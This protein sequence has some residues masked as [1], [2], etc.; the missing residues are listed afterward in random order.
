M[1]VTNN[2]TRSATVFYKVQGKM[3]KVKLLPFESLNINEVT[4]INAV[5][6]NMV[7]SNFVASDRAAYLATLSAN[8]AATVV[9]SYTF[10]DGLSVAA[11]QR[12]DTGFTYNQGNF[13]ANP[14]VYSAATPQA[15]FAVRK[16]SVARQTKGRFEVKY[17]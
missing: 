13:A 9:T 4:D 3:K 1:K 16:T 2:R 17:R 10:N 5:K 15:T 6:N 11:S 12:V 7:I 8:T 14:S